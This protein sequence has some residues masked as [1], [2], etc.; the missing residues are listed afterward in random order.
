M[1][2]RGR[3]KSINSGVSDNASIEAKAEVG[4]ETGKAIE[5]L[6]K[7]ILALSERVDKLS[8]NDV[9]ENKEVPDK[10]ES[11]YDDS[12]DEYENIKINQD[13]YIR[14]IS[15]CPFQLNLST[16]GG[17]RGKVYSFQSF[18][19]T[20]RILYS[21]LVNVL[22]NYNH[23]L[24]DGLFFIA[25]KR[26]IRRHGYDELYSKILSKEMIEKILDGTRGADTISIIKSTS[27]KQQ[28][29]IAQMFIDRR[30]AG[31]EVD[32]NL[33]DK[34]ERATDINMQEKYEN[35]LEYL[36][37]RIQVKAEQKEKK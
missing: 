17:G 11:T 22:E 23:F 31:Q 13:A 10:K 29:M 18:G 12:D 36:D 35:A 8:G 20:K 4:N 21:D 6:M 5:A 28:E 14:V 16:E 26:V 2:T 7:A 15:L 33:W 27:K 9:Q 3:P 1:A 37:S 32:L 34:I 19:S 30:L 24:N 25:D